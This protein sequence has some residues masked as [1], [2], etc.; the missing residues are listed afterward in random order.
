M[1][2][3]DVLIP[4]TVM[5]KNTALRIALFSACFLA[6]SLVLV[7]ELVVG[8]LSPRGLGIALLLLFI[9][10]LIVFT[11]MVAAD[12]R[13]RSRTW[14]E[15]QPLDHTRRKIRLGKI[16]IVILMVLLLNGFFELRHGLVFPLLVGI[17][18]NI[19]ITITIARTVLRLQKSLKNRASS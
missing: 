7:R 14:P 15:G 11:R 5:E 16:A 9:G 8:F 18:M 13:T 6:I 10:S 1:Q 3:G 19:L 17:G 12:V 4:S 2:D